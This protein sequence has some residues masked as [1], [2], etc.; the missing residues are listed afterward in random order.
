LSIN[1]DNKTKKRK[2][3]GLTKDFMNITIFYKEEDEKK[4]VLVAN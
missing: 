1:H 4:D 2:T 3:L